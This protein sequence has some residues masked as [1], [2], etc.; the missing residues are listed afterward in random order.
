M[1]H[2]GVSQNLKLWYCLHNN[3]NYF[4]L[5]FVV[6]R[7]LMKVCSSLIDTKLNIPLLLKHHRLKTF[8]HLVYY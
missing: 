5:I 6:D 1:R 4:K 3:S 8:L 2:K 7:Y